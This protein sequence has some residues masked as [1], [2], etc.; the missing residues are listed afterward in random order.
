MLQFVGHS[1]IIRFEAV[2][3]NLMII[4]LIT[5]MRVVRT[6]DSV[7]PNVN[8]V[9]KT[10]SKNILTINIVL[11]NF[12]GTIFVSLVGRVPQDQVGSTCNYYK[13]IHMAVTSARMTNTQRLGGLIGFMG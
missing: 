11:I 7:I 8:H 1:P 5:I 2:D 9:V 13:H 4:N 6:T 3:L 12:F 10:E